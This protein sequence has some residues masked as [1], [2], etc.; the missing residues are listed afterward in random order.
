MTSGLEILRSKLP[1][2]EPSY[3][4]SGLSPRVEPSCFYSRQGS[5]IILKIF[6]PL[7]NHDYQSAYAIAPFGLMKRRVPASTR[8]HKLVSKFRHFMLRDLSLM[9]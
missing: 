4:Y 8:V 7:V 6:C 3:F 9:R 2:V 5:L 1:A